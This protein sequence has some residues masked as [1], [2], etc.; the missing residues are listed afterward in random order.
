MTRAMVPWDVGTPPTFENFRQEM[1]RLMNRFIRPDLGDMGGF[2]PRTNVAETENDYEVSVDLP[3]MKPEDVNIELRE[4]QLW[5]TG[6]R[7]EEKEEKGKAFHRVERQYGQFRRV[8]PLAGPVESDKIDA[9]FKE[10]VLRVTVPKSE[11]AKPKRIEV[12]T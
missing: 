1:D 2:M 3:G 12:K 6:E 5:I 9:Q 7:K 11:K 4:N 10:G 8:V